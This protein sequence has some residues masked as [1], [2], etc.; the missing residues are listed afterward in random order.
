MFVVA[1]ERRHQ[2]A[3]GRERDFA[4]A[5][6]AP[7]AALGDRAMTQL[8]LGHQESGFGGVAVDL[9][10][11]ARSLAQFGVAGQA[12][13]AQH[14]DVLGGPAPSSA[15]ARSTRPSGAYPTP[16]TWVS[17]E[18][19]ITRSMVISER[20]SVPVLSEQMT[21]AQ[22]SVSTSRPTPGS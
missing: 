7:L 8:A 3:L 11:A 21:E 22:P 1:F 4:D 12:A 14:D 5:L 20:V 18:A 2:L 9:P 16:L 17:P 15:P 10:R 19:V 13:A 6:E